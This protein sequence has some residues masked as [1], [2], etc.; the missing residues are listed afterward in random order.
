[1]KKAADVEKK[2]AEK[3]DKAREKARSKGQISLDIRRLAM[4]SRQAVEV[5]TFRNILSNPPMATGEPKEP[6]RENIGK[7]APQEALLAVRR[8]LSDKK[9]NKAQA[10][11]DRLLAKGSSLKAP[12]QSRPPTPPSVAMEL[13]RPGKQRVRVLSNAVESTFKADV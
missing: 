12:R 1:M 7:N 8:T 5:G 9:K 3:Q 11:A 6:E 2:M 10:M 4:N 13:I